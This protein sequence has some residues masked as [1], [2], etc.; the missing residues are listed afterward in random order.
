ME[1]LPSQS[2]ALALDALKGQGM[3]A[4][5]ATATV[6]RKHELNFALGEMCLLRTTTDHG[7]GLTALR[8]QRRA[9]VALNQLHRDAVRASA[10]ELRTL[11][12][13][14]VP[15][16]AFGLAPSAPAKA[17]ESGPAEPDLPL[18]RSRLEEFLATVRAR[19]PKVILEEGYLAFTRADSVFA[20]SNGV[21]WSARQ[22]WYSLGLMFTP[23]DGTRT[24][25]FN[26]T[27]GSWRALD[28]PVI[29][30]FGLADLLAQSLDT[31]DGR[32]CAGKFTGE[33][34]LTPHVARDL[35]ESYLG[36]LADTPLI[37][38][39]SVFRGKLG[40]RVA[41]PLL[42]LHSDPRA[43]GL[44]LPEFFDGDG[45]ETESM[46]V[47]DRGVLAS[48]LLSLYGANKTGLARAKSSGT[49]Y[50]LL[51]GETPREE[52]LAGVKKGIVLG[53]FSG[54][55]PSPSGDFSGVAKNS[56]FVEN[57]RIVHPLGETMISGNL[58]RLFENVMGVSRESI[59]FGSKR[60]PWLLSSG[61]T[62]AGA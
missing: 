49:R 41:S 42:S 57:G 40:E 16:P 51:A 26:Y 29:E 59:S 21:H 2:A 22:G 45:F 19:Y 14:G 15:D 18:L 8:E 25:S 60:L 47:L 54:G 50:T 27:M 34:L 38:N 10:S 62:V 30:S 46:R 32:P 11:S 17:F 6:S 44:A 39:T 48:Y 1:T 52:L 31:L 56:Y 58:L 61:V 28:A 5:S 43:E 9:Q 36:Y 55:R 33:V 4:G 3:D 23:K 37:S 20:N 7:L 35:L 12:D 53:R 24:G 13:A